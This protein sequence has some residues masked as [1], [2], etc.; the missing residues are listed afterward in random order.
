M[1]LDAGSPIMKFPCPKDIHAV[2][3]LRAW[4]LH[5]AQAVPSAKGHRADQGSLIAGIEE[6]EVFR[7][8]AGN[9]LEVMSFP[10]R[11]GDWVVVGNLIVQ[12]LRIPSGAD[13][14]VLVNAGEFVADRPK[15][16]D[17]TPYP[18]TST[19]AKTA[20]TNFKMTRWT[21]GKR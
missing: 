20:I 14:A 12:L 16:C 7:L 1:H 10:Q 18:R 2:T 3:R 11:Y 8:V 17:P 6:F 4:H 19:G 15:F 21:R 5:D 9:P 13:L